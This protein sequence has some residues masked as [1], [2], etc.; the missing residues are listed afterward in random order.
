MLSRQQVSQT[1]Q[2]IECAADVP[3]RQIRSSIR[4]SL[5]D[6]LPLSPA[7]SS[8]PL[9]LPDLGVCESD[10]VAAAVRLAVCPPFSQAGGAEI[11]PLPVV[12]HAP[13]QTVSNNHPCQRPRERLTFEG[14]RRHA[15]RRHPLRCFVLARRCEL[16]R[17]AR[18]VAR[19]ARSHVRSHAR[20]RHHTA[21]CTESAQCSLW[22]L[23]RCCASS[24]C[25]RAQGEQLPGKGR[26]GEG[27]EEQPQR[28]ALLAPFVPNLAP[29]RSQAQDRP[30]G[31]MARLR[32][33]WRVSRRSQGAHRLTKRCNHAGVCEQDGTGERS[34]AEAG[35]GKGARAVGERARDRQRGER[36]R[37]GGRG[38]WARRERRTRV[39]H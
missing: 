39:L 16:R 8:V 3:P 28:G 36:G 32:E 1:K 9:S 30:R 31:G 35:W 24:C 12:I 6:S 2:H 34:V 11:E 37:E 20:E 19:S 4:P 27:H 14:M 10:G 13:P 25:S 7:F 15:S 5:R 18:A 22:R 29:L 26:E 33:V 23:E 38:W 21:V 17:S